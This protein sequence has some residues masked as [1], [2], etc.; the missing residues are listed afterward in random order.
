[1]WWYSTEQGHPRL[2]CTPIR[3]TCVSHRAFLGYNWAV[4]RAFLPYW[5]PKLSNYFYYLIF[6]GHLSPVWTVWKFGGKTAR[7]ETARWKTAQLTAGWPVRTPANAVSSPSMA[8]SSIY[9]VL[10]A[11]ELDRSLL[12]PTPLYILVRLVPCPMVILNSGWSE[13][14]VQIP[15]LDLNLVYA[16]V[17]HRSS[18]VPVD[19]AFGEGAQIE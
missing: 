3:S 11:V 12:D 17:Y 18:R 5:T 16:I 1:M 10:R 13:A 7:W 2:S 9:M 6:V 4:T 19:R 8:Q 14:L 15:D